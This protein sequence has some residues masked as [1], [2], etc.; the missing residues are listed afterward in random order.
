MIQNFTF[1]AGV[2]HEHTL[3][4]TNSEFAPENRPG[5]KRKY[6]VNQPSIS[7]AFAVSFREGSNG[8]HKKSPISCKVYIYIWEILPIII[9]QLFP[10]K[11]PSPSPGATTAVAWQR[12]LKKELH[13]SCAP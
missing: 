13:D 6:H 8:S 4:E 3:P 10:V 2:F 12:V 9:C 7:G 11:F 1:C 5:P